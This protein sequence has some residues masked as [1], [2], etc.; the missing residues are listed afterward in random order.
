LSQAVALADRAGYPVVLKIDSPGQAHIS[1]WGG[2]RLNLSDQDQVRQAYTDLMNAARSS[3]E[4]NRIRGIT[5]Q[6]MVGSPSAELAIGIRTDDLFG[7]VL[8]FGWGGIAREISQD[9]AYTLPPLNRLLARRMIEGAQ[10][11]RLL[12]GYRDHAPANIALL[13]EILI[14]LAQLATDFAQIAEIVIN[15]LLVVDQNFCAVSARV[16][17]YPASVRAPLHL[18]IAPYP[19]QYETVLDLQ[20]EGP[21]QIRPIRP[22]DAPLLKAFFAS[23]SSKSIYFRFFSPLKEL[24]YGMLARFTQIDYDREIAMVAIQENQAGDDEMLGVGRIISGIDPTQAEFAILVGDRWHG[25]GIGAALLRICLQIARIQGVHH[26]WG[27][28]MSDNTQ[29]LALGRKLGFKMSRANGEYELRMNLSDMKASL[30][31]LN[32][33]RD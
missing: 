20:E 7:P 27:V 18:V 16:R 29:M 3:S 13:E 26:I 23:L 31:S 14:R 19:N 32:D 28:V 24:P 30:A 17:V 10:V 4:K 9:R 15:P 25:R 1:H 33:M 6:K 8:S 21:I 2:V 5:V 12:K 22:E 11:Y